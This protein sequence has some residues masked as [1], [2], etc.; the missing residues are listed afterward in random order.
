MPR[1]VTELFEAKSISTRFRVLVSVASRQ[2]WVQQKNVAAD[3]GITVQAVSEHMKELVSAGLIESKGRSS[4]SV[5]PLGVDW[6]LR[7]ARQLETY[8]ERVGDL[9]KDISVTAALA[10]EDLVVGQDVALEMLDGLLYARAIR[11]GDSASATVVVAGVKGTDVGVSR[12]EGVIPL[13][14][15]QVVLAI[16]P[17]ISDGGSRRVDAVSLK[18]AASRA[19]LV[20]AVGV[21]ALASLRSCGVEPAS[22]W[23]ATPASIEAALSGVSGLLACTRSESSRVVE[24]LTDAG[25]PFS[26]VDLSS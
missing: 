5:T 25:V 2:P 13:S 19:S 8:T 26:L 7:M 6:L 1:H 18:R 17:S 15:A 4:Y 21:E 11:E 22:W 20:A 16:V 3:L 23:A 10:A 9:V 12:I 14:P 24:R